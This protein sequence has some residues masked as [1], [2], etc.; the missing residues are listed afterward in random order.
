MSAFV[1][2]TRP[3]ASAVCVPAWVRLRV[4]VCVGMTFPH[5]CH[6]TESL[7]QKLKGGVVNTVTLS[8]EQP[9][10]IISC[11]KQ[12]RQTGDFQSHFGSGWP[13]RVRIPT[14]SLPP[15]ISLPLILTSLCLSA[16]V[17]LSGVHTD[18]NTH[19]QCDKSVRRF[20]WLIAWLLKQ[21]TTVT[22]AWPSLPRC[23]TSDLYLVFSGRRVKAACQHSNSIAAVVHHLLHWMHSAATLLCNWRLTDQYT[24]L[25]FTYRNIQNICVLCLLL[26]F[27]VYQ[28]SGTKPWT[29][30]GLSVKQGFIPERETKQ[31]CQTLQGILP[32]VN[33]VD[34]MPSI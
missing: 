18:W 1:K 9:V 2:I 5:S 6:F 19:L 7:K 30:Q 4:R 20:Q 8:A 11:G 29:R 23:N 22:T 28:I 15:T 3:T 17:L 26:C 25:D 31:K 12:P 21:S 27:Y 14:F 34:N 24:S 10:H 32:Q 13:W 16:F 33:V